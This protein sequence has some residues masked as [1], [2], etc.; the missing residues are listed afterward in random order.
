MDQI[1]IRT[2]HLGKRLG[3]DLQTENWILKDINIQWFEG[4]ITAL[5]GPNGAGKTTLMR[6]LMQIIQPSIGKIYYQNEP[7]QNKHLLS[8]GYL[9]EERGLYPRM[10][11]Q[12]QLIYLGQLR[13]LTVKK[14]TENIQ[15]WFDQL[16]VLDWKNKKITQ[17]SK[18]MAQKIQFIAAVLHHPDCII[19][20]EPFTGLDPINTALIQGQIIRLKEEGKTIL[21]SSHNIN[22]VENSCDY[23]VLLHKG[24]KILEGSLEE[25]KNRG[26]IAD[27]F[28]ELTQGNLN[29][30]VLNNEY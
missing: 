12:D 24:R 17:I 19:L 8:M 25:I 23:L 22:I 5:L 14:A 21:L 30:Y 20:D 13:G 2:E 1:F 3:S 28:L 11:V 10:S 15:F 7:L 29:K 4:K 9:P 26:S 16:E 6:L 27:I 18:G